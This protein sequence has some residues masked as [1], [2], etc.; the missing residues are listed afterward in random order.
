M[1]EQRLYEI[2]N[3]KTGQV[4]NRVKSNEVR[5]VIGLPRHIQIGQIANSKDKTYKNWYVQILGDRCERVFRKSKIY[6]FTKKTYKQ[7]ENLNRRY[8]AKYENGM[9]YAW[10]DGATSWSVPCSDDMTRWKMAKLAESEDAEEQ[11]RMIIFPCNKG[12]KIYE[13]Y[14]ECVECRLEAGETPEDI[15]SMRRV[16]YF[17]YDGDETYIYASQALP[18]RLFNN[19]ELF[20]IPASEIGKTVFLSYEEAEAKLKELRGGEDE[21]SN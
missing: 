11:G 1:S 6:P 15:I 10:E 3:L 12:D 20:C 19:D 2:V 14:L 13:F 8:F 21:S 9:L 4:Y 7:W 17:G 16:R 5:M 18:V